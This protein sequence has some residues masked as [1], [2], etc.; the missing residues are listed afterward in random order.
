[1]LNVKTHYLFQMIFRQTNTIINNKV[2]CTCSLYQQWP[3]L[4][5]LK[6]S[7]Y[8]LTETNKYEFS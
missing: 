2:T 7:I 4:I 3:L 5:L 6:I 8:I 1:V